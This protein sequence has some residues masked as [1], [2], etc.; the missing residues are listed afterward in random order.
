MYLHELRVRPRTLVGAGT[1]SPPRRTARLGRACSDLITGDNGVTLARVTLV[2]IRQASMSP[3]PGPASAA[4]CVDTPPPRWPLLLLLNFQKRGSGTKVPRTDSGSDGSMMDVCCTQTSDS[5]QSTLSAAAAA[6]AAAAGGAAAAAVTA[7]GPSA[8]CR[9][10]CC[11]HPDAAEQLVASEECE[12]SGSEVEGPVVDKYIKGTRL[13]VNG[14][15]QACRCAGA[16]LG[17]FH[18]ILV[19]F[20][21]LRLDLR[22][23]VCTPKS[24]HT[25]AAVPYTSESRAASP[26]RTLPRPPAPSH[27]QGLQRAHGAHLGHQRAGRTPLPQVCTAGRSRPVSQMPSW[28]HQ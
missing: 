21:T 14:W 2:P 16:V 18:N 22:R 11:T 25:L 13:I 28:A 26:R 12:F 8:A 17:L 3:L 19:A 15:F 27:P 9:N 24:T 5:A 23:L 6:A 20:Q 7:T 10:D 1:G 4:P